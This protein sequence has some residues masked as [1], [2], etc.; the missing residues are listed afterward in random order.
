MIKI[1]DK[2]LVKIL[3]CIRELRHFED[4]GWQRFGTIPEAEKYENSLCDKLDVFTEMYSISEKDAVAEGL[5]RKLIILNKLSVEDAREF[6]KKN[7]PDAET[8]RKLIK[9]GNDYG[10]GR[11]VEIEGVKYNALDN[12]EVNLLTYDAFIETTVG[13]VINFS[14]RV[15][16]FV[17]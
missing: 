15:F 8:Y 11:Y 3:S 4:R 17:V 5:K 6:L 16:D 14:N 2:D 12:F 1:E 7:I 10:Y 13:D 9:K